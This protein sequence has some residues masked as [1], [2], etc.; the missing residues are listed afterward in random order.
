MQCWICMLKALLIAFIL[1]YTTYFT[2]QHRQ[3][4]S[5][6]HISNT[7]INFIATRHHE[8]AQLWIL[9]QLFSKG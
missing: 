3:N 2:R 4:G 1:Q 5:S 7:Q 9:T 6:I 8:L